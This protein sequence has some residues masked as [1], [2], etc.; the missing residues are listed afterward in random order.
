MVRADRTVQFLEDVY[1]E[2][3]ALERALD[4]SRAQP[5]RGA[6]ALPPQDSRVSGA[7]L[8][9]QQSASMDAALDELITA[10]EDLRA[11][12]SAAGR[13]AK[14]RIEASGAARK[15]R[16]RARGDAA[17]ARLDGELRA[18]ASAADAEI[19]D[20]KRMR[21]AWIASRKRKAQELVA[22]AAQVWASIVRD[23]VRR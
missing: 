19:E 7:A 15:D 12:V 14:A 18:L 22:P 9:L 1:G 3:A 11:R 21:A 4:R 13:A 20:R 5:F 6:A 16:D 23:G 10:D 8:G 17:S 2:D